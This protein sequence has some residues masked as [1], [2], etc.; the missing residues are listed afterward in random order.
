MK[1]TSLLCLSLLLCPFF[2]VA[3]DQKIFND[4][5]FP[6]LN[7]KKKISSK[8]NT[9]LYK[10]VVEN[11]TNK[12]VGMDQKDIDA[13]DD[14]QFAIDELVERNIK[15]EQSNIID[16]S[17]P[18]EQKKYTLTQKIGLASWT[19][20][21]LALSWLEKGIPQEWR[22]QALHDF[23][24][25]IGQELK[26]V[27]KNRNGNEDFVAVLEAIEKTSTK[28]HDHIL[29]M[30][31]YLKKNEDN[32]VHLDKFVQVDQKGLAFGSSGLLGDTYKTLE[33][34]KK[35]DLFV[36]GLIAQE[37]QKRVLDYQRTCNYIYN[38]TKDN[39]DVI[40]KESKDKY[41]NPFVVFGEA[42]DLMKELNKKIEEKQ[43]KELEE[44][45]R[46]E[47]EQKQKQEQKK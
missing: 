11:N 38:M 18:V 8:S 28:R 24:W 30:L 45:Q 37:I 42:Q 14:L 2:A 1:R 25:A 47:L 7:Q 39:K 5:N 12:T 32:M 6:K 13:L 41:E 35:H 34:E 3:M 26:D 23:D 33:T 43:Q 17:S 27:K 22:D 31:N 4:K 21:D 19:A 46:K 36:L 10:D 9:T 40:G 44:K 20:R 15:A 29:V 16:S